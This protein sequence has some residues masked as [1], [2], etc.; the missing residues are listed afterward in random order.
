MNII[1]RI[2]DLKLNTLTNIENIQ[3]AKI[4]VVYELEKERKYSF[5]I[6][7]FYHSAYDDTWLLYTCRNLPFSSNLKRHVF[8]DKLENMIRNKEIK[9]FLIFVD[10]KLVK[11][12]DIMIIKDCNFAYLMIQNNKNLMN[13]ICECILLPE[14]IIYKEDSDAVT[15]HTIFAFNEE[16]LMVNSIGEG[17]HTT[18]DLM[19]KDVSYYTTQ[20][21]EGVK[22]TASIDTKYKLTKSNFI[23]FRDGLL[24]ANPDIEVHG[25]NVYSVNNNRFSG[26]NYV[27]KQF[28]YTKSNLCLDNITNPTNKNNV[29]S[30]LNR[31]NI[32]PHILKLAE[33]FDFQFDRNKEYTENITDALLYIMTYNTR[34]M[35]EIYK[36]SST[37]YTRVYSGKEINSLKNEKGYVTMSRRIDGTSENYPIIFHNGLLYDYYNEL[38]YKN[39]NFTFPVVDVADSDIIEIIFFKNVDNRKYPLYLASGDDNIEFFDSTIDLNNYKLYSI[40]PENQIF[41]IER[42]IRTQYEVPFTFDKVDGNKYHIKLGNS[43]HYDRNLTLSSDKQFRH[44]TKIAQTDLIDISLS[45]DFYYC[46]DITKY[47]VFKN[48]RK[49]DA[50][51]FILTLPNETRP[52]DDISIYFKIP[53]HEG[54]KID[55]FYVPTV[56]EVIA[57]IDEVDSDSGFIVIDRNKISYDLDNELYMIFINGKKLDSTHLKPM[58]SNRLKLVVDLESTKNLRIIKHVSDNEILKKLFKATKSVLDV[59]YK[60]INHYELRD[61]FLTF[62]DYE[63]KEDDIYTEQ[64]SVDQILY[65]IIQ[66]YYMRP[67]INSGDIIDYT[68]MEFESELEKDSDSNTLFSTMDATKED[69]LEV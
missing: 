39:K 53:I 36:E 33:S 18:V 31:N 51:R 49:I 28:Y 25:L 15:D 30:R 62:N 47:M 9:P 44:M 57:E 68:F 46:T 17:R 45:S 29:L 6:H 41:N 56:L 23:I 40:N 43:Y 48:G 42:T 19:D 37:L 14:N 12:S 4:P 55:I 1:E 11:W 69:K 38:K 35:N 26:E 16:G 58:D 8:S 67:Y 7:G 63:N 60:D 22:Q 10:H 52:F 20:L 13:P 65:K 64:I 3:R 24:E 61:L 27:V 54:D 2:E 32:P 21:V 50:D 5:D 34:L 59:T 66:D